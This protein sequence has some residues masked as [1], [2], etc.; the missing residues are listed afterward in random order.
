MTETITYLL[1]HTALT[2]M[3]DLP[4]IIVTTEVTFFHTSRLLLAALR[5]FIIPK[6]IRLKKHRRTV[7]FQLKEKTCIDERSKCFGESTLETPF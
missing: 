5:D 3:S 4:H 1:T 7:T 2:I 6:R